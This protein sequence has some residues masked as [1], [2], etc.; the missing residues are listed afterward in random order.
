MGGRARELCVQDALIRYLPAEHWRNQRDRMARQHAE[1]VA[2][3]RRLRDDMG[4]PAK[5]WPDEFWSGYEATI[6]RGQWAAVRCSGW[7]SCPFGTEDPLERINA[8]AWM[9]G[10]CHP[11][12]LAP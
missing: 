2:R 5:D 4:D 9:F 1:S 11:E 7:Q 6:R 10:Y 3:L 8:M 12:F